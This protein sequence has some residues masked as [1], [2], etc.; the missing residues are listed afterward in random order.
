[1]VGFEGIHTTSDQS[2]FGSV[3]DVGST[4]VNSVLIKVQRNRKTLIR[5]ENHQIY[6]D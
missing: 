6:S 4:I 2:M 5:T 1:M 3:S